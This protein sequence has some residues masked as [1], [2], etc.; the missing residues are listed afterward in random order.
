MVDPYLG[1]RRN[2]RGYI[3][4]PPA[5]IHP[6]ILFGHGMAL[7]PYFANK[8]DITH[9]INCAFDEHSPFWFR[10]SCPNN[11]ICL[12]AEDALDRNIID[13]Y[14]KFEENMDKFLKDSSCQT[15]YVHCQ[16]GINRSGFLTL[17]YGCLHLGL[18]FEVLV[19]A[20]LIQRPCAL[21]NKHYYHLVKDYVKKHKDK[22]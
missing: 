3:L 20:I 7:T 6:R 10:D 18:S 17:L 5:K 1:Y 16:A 22:E 14:P 2:S 15:V 12:Q 8:Y 4:D 9:V 11:Y 19:K 21:T 13:W